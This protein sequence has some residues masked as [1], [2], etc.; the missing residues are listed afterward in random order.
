MASTTGCLVGAQKSGILD[1]VSYIAGISGSCWALSGLYSLAGGHLDVWTSHIKSRITTPFLD[2]GNFQLFTDP[3]TNKVSSTP[4][5]EPPFAFYS[6]PSRRARLS[7][8]SHI[9]M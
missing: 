3:P 2:L 5:A 4:S 7:H 1:V 9:F 6:T 8:M